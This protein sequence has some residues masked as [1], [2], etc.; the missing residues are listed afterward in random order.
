MFSLI[1]CPPSPQ[2]LYPHDGSDSGLHT[3]SRP[4]VS[5]ALAEKL[6]LLKF[7]EFKLQ[8]RWGGPLGGTPCLKVTIDHSS[9]SNSITPSI[10]CRSAQSWRM[11]RTACVTGAP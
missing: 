6:D 9:V 8:V 11:S 5:A 4:Q 3:A 1:S 10:P 2:K 7:N